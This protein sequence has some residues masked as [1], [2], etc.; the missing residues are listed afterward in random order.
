[1]T[2]TRLKGTSIMPT[3]FES[4]LLNV[5]LFALRR[6][7][8]LREA[9]DWFIREFNPESFEELVALV[10]GERN[11]A[12]R[13]VLGYWDMAASLVT[14]GAIDG[15][16]FRAAHGEIFATFSKIHPFLGEIRSASGEPEFCRHMEAVVMAAADAEAM[17][18]RRRD[19]A[20]AA[21][22]ARRLEPLPP[23]P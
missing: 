8:V 21:S 7:P 3:P 13:M 10:G 18:A 22:K 19:A 1:L 2:L 14:S 23:G 20:L 6:E 11:A 16:A 17:L 15:D 12:F 5:E 4:G 9:R